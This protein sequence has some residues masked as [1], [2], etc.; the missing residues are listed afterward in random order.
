LI[1]K[2]IN[3]NKKIS[4][5]DDDAKHTNKYNQEKN[6]LMT[7]GHIHHG[8]AS[9]FKKPFKSILKNISNSKADE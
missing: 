7:R 8:P 1:N 5:L 2:S 6:N 3:N 9:H 4:W